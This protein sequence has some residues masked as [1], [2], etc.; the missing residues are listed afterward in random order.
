MV[1]VDTSVL[2]HFS[3]V[4]KLNLLKSY[5][6]KITITA[7][8]SQ[9]MHA[10]ITGLSEFAKADW[11]KIERTNVLQAKELSKLEGIEI[12]DASL[13]LLAKNMND[14]LLTNDAYLVIVAKSKGV[15]CLWPTTFVL[16][17][18]K[19][20]VI[21]KSEAKQIIYELVHSGMHLKND[22]YSAILDSIDKM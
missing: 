9:E 12:A 18:L 14:V 6:G 20:K 11:I 13:L 10:G 1:I 21:T 4:N 15:E 17:C 22:V 8:V 2:I 5:F 19:K 3:R 16:T 7:E